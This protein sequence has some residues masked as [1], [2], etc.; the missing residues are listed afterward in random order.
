MPTKERLK[1]NGNE[2]KEFL[3]QVEALKF[4]EERSNEV[5]TIPKEI[6]NS[7]KEL[8]SVFGNLNA[9]LRTEG[10]R[11]GMDR[12]SEFANILFLKLLSEHREDSIWENIKSQDDKYIISHINNTVIKDIKKRYG[13][14]VF[15]PLQIKNPATLRRMIEALDPLALT[16]IDTDIKG[17]AFEFFLQKTTST[18]NDLGEYFTPRH[19]IKTMINLVNPQFNEK[20]YDPFCGTGGF[21]TVAFEYIR[22]NSQ[23]DHTA[24]KKLQEESLFGRE[25]TSTARIAKMNMILHGDGHTGVKTNG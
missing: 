12:F 3:R 18:Q 25:I 6:I 10:L 4:L 14:E 2:V 1:L 19:I 17:D 15:N 22:N 23:L 21:L 24:L 11:A 7:R 16:P 5:Y 9:I 20:I 8:I 13:G